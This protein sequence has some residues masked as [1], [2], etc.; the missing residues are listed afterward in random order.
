MSAIKVHL[1]QAEYDAV[2]RYAEKLGVSPEDI[3]FAALNR[4]ML[5][6]P[7]TDVSRDIVET[8]AWRGQNLPLWS[9]SACAVHAYEGKPDDEPEPSRKFQ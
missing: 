6:S 4:L 2:V 5:M 1:E 7:K 9:D 3:A 8:R